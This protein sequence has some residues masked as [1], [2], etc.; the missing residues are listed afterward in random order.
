MPESPAANGGES[1]GAKAVQPHPSSFRPDLTT[2]VFCRKTAGIR[3]V[4]PLEEPAAPNIGNPASI[5]F[6]NRGRL[7]VFCCQKLRSR[8]Q[9]IISFRNV[10]FGTVRFNPDW[11]G[12]RFNP[13]RFC[14]VR[15]GFIRS[16]PVSRE[17]QHIRSSHGTPHPGVSAKYPAPEM[18]VKRP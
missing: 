13:D 6:R 17:S 12:T 16:G 2:S 7:F 15:S 11:T 5:T 18:P 3:R 14:P 4:P 8:Q 1:A 9:A 10:R